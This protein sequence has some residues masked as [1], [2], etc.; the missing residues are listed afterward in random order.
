MND[1]HLRASLEQKPITEGT[2]EDLHEL[3]QAACNLELWTLPLYLTALASIREDRSSVP[4]PAPLR[5]K[6][7][8]RQHDSTVTRLVLS[9]ALQEMY[10]LQLAGNL[11]R[12]FGQVPRLDWPRYDGGIPYIHPQPSGL[13]V[14][15]GKVTDPDVVAVMVAVETPDD[16][17]S[18]N[19]APEA[20][21]VPAYGTIDT[22]NGQPA[23]PSIGALYSVIVQLA[24]RFRGAMNAGAPQL[25]N[26]LF[27]L[28]YDHTGLIN[29]SSFDDAANIIVDQG[30]GAI[31]SQF[32]PVNASDA[33]PDQRALK[34]PFFAENHWSH[35]E[36]FERVQSNAARNVLTWPTNA[37][38]D[39]SPQQVL[40]VLFSALL[41]GMREGWAGGKPDLRPM[42]LLRA[43]LAQVYRSGQIP[44][45]ASVDGS[46]GFE[47]A[48]E[49]LA[50]AQGACWSEHVQWFFALTDIAAMKANAV[51]EPDLGDHASV[52]QHQDAVL[53]TVQGEQMPPGELNRW[54]MAQVASFRSWDGS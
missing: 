50:P 17:A 39:A 22:L 13:T 24:D 5:D 43:A 19:L 21:D 27:S 12:I 54:L 37:A 32:A 45:F 42:F 16:Y 34:D 40:S 47:D 30:E 33:L 38:S 36:R 2:L 23:Y 53:Q 51:R 44:H 15:L 28:W 48:V 3:L 20:P 11:T 35:L 25:A 4:L 26:G 1:T 46:V 6:L 10:H 14:K 18:G 31:G 49:A 52:R 29:P 9:V 7:Q 8:G 41:Q